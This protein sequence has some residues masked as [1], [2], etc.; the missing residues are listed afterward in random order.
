MKN[1]VK[2]IT[3]NGLKLVG[4]IKLQPTMQHVTDSVYITNDTY[5]QQQYLATQLLNRPFN[6]ISKVNQAIPENGNIL[7]LG[8]KCTSVLSGKDDPDTTEFKDIIDTT[9]QQTNH[10]LTLFDGCKTCQPDCQEIYKLFQNIRDYHIWIN[11]VKDILLYDQKTCKNLYY[12]LYNNITKYSQATQK[13]LSHC[14]KN[15]LPDRDLWLY[16]IRLVYQYKALVALWNYLAESKSKYTQL[17]TASQDFSG[18]N[19]ICKSML[20]LCQYTL[21]RDQNGLSKQHTIGLRLRVSVP[22][23]Q[24]L[25]VDKQGNPKGK[26]ALFFVTDNNNTYIKYIQQQF[27]SLFLTDNGSTVSGS[28]TTVQNSLFKIQTHLSGTVVKGVDTIPNI[29]NAQ[30]LFTI[31]D[32][33]NIGGQAQLSAFFK[34]IP[35][36]VTE[37]WSDHIVSLTDYQTFRKHNTQM[38]QVSGFNNWT[39]DYSWYNKTQD[40]NKILTSDTNIYR[41]PYTRVPTIDTI[42]ELT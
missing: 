16:G 40:T 42:L 38:P 24:A 14:T 11:S 30:V 41:T 15:D 39:V 35:V 10:T 32:N 36:W 25:P 27:N 13:A 3:I 29:I 8:Q 31:K 28:N 26:F 1:Y 23:S 18:I 9:K 21:D 34:I 2:S 7:L 17:S 19:I 33:K 22:N 37:A 5:T 12:E 4:D 20:D 6:L